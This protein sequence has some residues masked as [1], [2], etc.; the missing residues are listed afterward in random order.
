MTGADNAI[1]LYGY[2]Y[3]KQ[4][5]R[6]CPRGCCVA[7]GVDLFSADKVLLYIVCPKSHPMLMSENETTSRFLEIFPHATEWRWGLAERENIN[8]MRIMIVASNLHK[9]S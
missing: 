3:G 7:E 4:P 6:Q 8:E 2:G 9:K 1:V 5:P